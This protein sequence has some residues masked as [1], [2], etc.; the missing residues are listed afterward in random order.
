MIIIAATIQLYPPEAY[1]TRDDGGDGG[2]AA[3]LA[4]ALSP[5]VKSLNYLNNIMAK[6]EAN[7][8]RRRRRADAERGGLRGRMHGRQHFHREATA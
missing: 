4:G 5:A 1:E 7:H 6:I 3:R 2:D 8:A